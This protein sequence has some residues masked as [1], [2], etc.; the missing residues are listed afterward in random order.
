MPLG[1]IGY[2]SHGTHRQP[3]VFGRGS[4]AYLVPVMSRPEKRRSNVMGTLELVLIVVLI[5]FFV[6]GVGSLPHWRGGEGGYGTSGLLGVLLVVVLI[7]LLLR[8]M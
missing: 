3:S 6:G 2:R 7:C 4:G 5:L 8:L 1:V